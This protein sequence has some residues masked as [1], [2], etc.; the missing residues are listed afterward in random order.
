MKAEI[1]EDGVMIITAEIPI[2][3]YA[4]KKWSDDFRKVDTD[5]TMFLI[6]PVEKK[7]CG[8]G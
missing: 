8:R 6:K 1:N 7:T 4:L 2:E 3:E 5:G